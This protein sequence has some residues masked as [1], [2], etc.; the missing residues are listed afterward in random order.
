VS[1]L[2]KTST[3]DVAIIGAGP[4]GLAAAAHLRAAGIDI[5]VFGEPMSFWRS[6]PAGMLLRSN[7]GATNISDLLGELS[8]DSYKSATGAQFT[9][10]VPIERFI[11]YG[12]WVQRRVVP[13]VERRLVARVETHDGGFQLALDDGECLCS[14]R[15]V[16]AGGIAPF[17]WRPPHLAH[18]PSDLVS[19]TSEHRQFD[20]FR[21]KEIAVVGGGQSALESAALSKEAGARVEVF[22]RSSRIVWLRG[23]AVKQRLGR[24]GHIVYAPT[25][26]GPLWYSRLVAMP[27]VFRRL[28]RRLQTPIARRSIRPAGAHWLLAR[29]AGVPLR[30]GLTV[31]DARPVGSRLALTLDDGSVRAV[32]HLLLGTGYRVDA[33]RYPFLAP[34]L[35]AGV[36]RID[37]Y[38]VLAPGF[39]SS[40]PGLHFLGAPAAWSFGPIMRFVSGTWY[41]GRALTRCIARPASQRAV[42]SA[43]ADVLALGV[44]SA[45]GV[46]GPMS[47]KA[48]TR[49]SLGVSR[50]R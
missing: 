9:A 1:K 46:T 45:P 37:G 49:R 26:V 39:E 2:S 41:S 3:V 30:L 25:D 44:E 35:V 8:L 6:M 38:P 18:L 29:L 24:M 22:V 21:D 19:H 12:D 32:D 15:V 27:D 4:Y 13:D 31:R 7:W 5:R 14:R 10:P 17:A 40:L 50:V 20:H 23:L 34:E 33:A 43:S 28:P 36:R 16:V 48:A 42:R 47:P 11:E